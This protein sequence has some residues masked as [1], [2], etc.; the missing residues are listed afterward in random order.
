MIYRSPVILVLAA[1]STIIVSACNGGNPGPAL[2][3]PSA[4]VTA[5]L[6]STQAA[7]S[8]HLEVSVDGK[9]AVPLPVAGSSAAPIDLTGTTA[10]ADID[11]AGHA[12]KATVAVPA[13]LN[14][15]GQA[16]VVD[17]KSYIKS[18]LGGPLYQES[19]ATGSLLDPA[20]FGSVLDNLGD[21]LLKN[22]TK[23]VKGEDVA[24]GS[25]QCYTVT[26]VLTPADLGPVGSAVPAG[27]PVN[28]TGAT[29]D[30]TIQVEKDLPYHL[31]GITAVLSMPT[32]ASKLT[33]DLT[34]SKWDAP[35]TITAPP[36]DQIKPAS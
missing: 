12:A 10:S 19:A 29:L 34:A 22:P 27:L 17:G 31:A 33:L 23:L 24:C 4:I 15:S 21:L 9:A 30:L 11:L 20:Q 26:A 13:V 32:S 36:P 18:S 5:A 6:T 35:L 28:L 3:D 2:T 1:A 7:K 25:K 8:V 16:I 14:F